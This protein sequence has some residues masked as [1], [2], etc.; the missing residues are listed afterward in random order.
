[1]RYS[2]LSSKNIIY[3]IFIIRIVDEWKLIFIMNSYIFYV[4]NAGSS[5][6]LADFGVQTCHYNTK[7]DVE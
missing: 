1:M 6:K 5:L 7:F 4:E 2:N 3:S